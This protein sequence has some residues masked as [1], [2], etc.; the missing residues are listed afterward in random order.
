MLFGMLTSISDIEIPKNVRSRLYMTLIGL[1][2]I[3]KRKRDIVDLIWDDL[4]KNYENTSNDLIDPILEEL[5][6]VDQSAGDIDVELTSGAPGMTAWQILVAVSIRQ[7][8]N[9]TYDDLEV[10]FNQNMLLREFLQLPKCDKSTFSESRLGKNCRK[11][12]FHGPGV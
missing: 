4:S 12:G 2:E 5:G 9:A 3:Y 7:G 6:V 8:L 11:I 1:Q 10:Q